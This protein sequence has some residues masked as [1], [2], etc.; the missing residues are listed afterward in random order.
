MRTLVS[1]QKIVDL[2]PIPG[3]DSIEVAQ[4]LGWHVVV[5]KGEFQPGDLAVYFEIDSLLP[6]GS[7]FDFL[8]KNGTKKTDVGGTIVEGYR[9][10]TIKLRGQ[11]S[12]GLCLPPSTFP[13]L[14][15]PVEGQ[16]VTALLGVVQYERI[17]T[18]TTGKPKGA[19]PAFI[20]KTDETRIQ[21]VPEIL[22]QYAGTEVYVTEKLD[23]S[24]RTVYTE[25]G[26]LNVCSR[27]TNWLEESENTFWTAVKTCG[28]AGR[29]DELGTIALQGEVVGGKIQGNTLGLGTRVYFFSAYDYRAGRYLNYAEFVKLCADLALETVPLLDTRALPAAMGVDDWVAYATRRSQL[30]PEVWAEGVVVRSLHEIDEPLLGGRLSFKAINPEFLLKED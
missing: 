9:L 17:M 30:N 6:Q 11:L 19:F 3:A 23:G 7:A 29:A 26:V 2:R 1:I 16:D 21:S 14:T 25:D 27:T 28:L 5:K 12:Q 15:N 20:P 13:A 22:E 4:V 8:A 24:S 10:R 18:A